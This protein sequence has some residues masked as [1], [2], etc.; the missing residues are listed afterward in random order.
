[1][2]SHGFRHTHATLSLESGVN[3]KDVQRRL[4]HA[5]S[6]MTMNVYAHSVG[7]DKQTSLKFATYL[8]T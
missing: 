1:M 4:G 3:Y 7:N 2:S 8:S 6:D 5:S